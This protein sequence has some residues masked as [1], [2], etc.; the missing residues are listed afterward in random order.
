[1]H[2]DADGC[3]VKEEVIEVARRNGWRAVFVSAQDHP[4]LAGRQ[5]VE[6]L[7]AAPSFQAADRMLI[8]ML[9][10]GGVLVTGDLELAREALAA[11]A[12]V[13][14]FRGPLT[15]ANIGEAL[16]RRDL[17]ATAREHGA[18]ESGRGGRGAF[19]KEDR[20]RFKAALHGMLGKK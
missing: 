15:A 8:R 20:S 1:M 19:S 11:G 6:V 5:G 3:P 18:L 14:G 9:G 7:K 17:Y 2:V 10:P 13:C 12:L 4:R 16:A